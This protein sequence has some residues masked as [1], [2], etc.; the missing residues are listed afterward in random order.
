[1]PAQRLLFE[2]YTCPSCLRKLVKWLGGLRIRRHIYIFF[3]SVSFAHC[4]LRFISHLLR[5]PS[6]R[7]PHPASITYVYV[8]DEGPL[9]FYTHKSLYYQ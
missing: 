5:P 2:K 9:I 1:M 6:P 3:V 4:V 8:I 7:R